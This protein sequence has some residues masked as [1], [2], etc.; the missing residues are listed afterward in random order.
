MKNNKT[1]VSIIGLKEFR[2]NMEKYISEV[3]KGRSFTVVRKSK[4][5][6]NVVP[7][8][9]WGDEGIWETV[10]DFTKFKRGGMPVEEAL[11]HIRAANAQDRKVS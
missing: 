7:H 2:E 6:Y 8:D 9:V 5:I 3:K 11:K 4:P 10:I 1:S